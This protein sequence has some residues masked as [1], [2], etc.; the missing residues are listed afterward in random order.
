MRIRA[1]LPQ[2]QLPTELGTPPAAHNTYTSSSPSLKWTQASMDITGVGVL[3]HSQEV[4]D[5]AVISNHLWTLLISAGS[6]ARLV[7]NNAIIRLPLIAKSVSGCLWPQRS[8]LAGGPRAQ[9]HPCN[10]AGT[11]IKG[12]SGSFY[13][14]W[15]PFY[16]R[17]FIAFV[18]Q[19]ALS[20]CSDS[21]LT[22]FSL[23]LI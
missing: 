20:D 3:S 15:E 1:T 2:N 11:V 6:R 21:C 18:W 5:A 12:W 17:T 16:T 19:T 14:A 23:V 22:V 9:G 10:T 13:I 4:S 7:P 8:I